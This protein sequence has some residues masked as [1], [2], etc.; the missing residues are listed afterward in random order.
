MMLAVL[1]GAPGSAAFAQA[2][3]TVE[4]VR[5]I[6]ARAQ[7]IEQIAGMAAVDQ[8]M[9]T[10]MLEAT[11]K[12]PPQERDAILKPAG[13]LIVAQDRLHVARLKALIDVHGWPRISQTSERTSA[14]AVTLVNHAGFDLAFQR[15]AL[16]L[17]EPLAATREA[18]PE[19]YA[20]LYDRL[21]TVDKRP[22]RYGTQGTTCHDGRY[23]VPADLEAPE[24]LEARRAAVGL[25]PMAEYLGS[26]DKM[27][28]TCTQPSGG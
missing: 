15:Q 22:Q 13:A 23:A 14:A 7:I 21:A 24:G 10:T 25:S 19:D 16:A 27:Y 11:S 2:D 18:R 12:L 28:G 4:R 9:R 1:C 6:A 3:A 5:A 20:R 26:L 17:I 8:A